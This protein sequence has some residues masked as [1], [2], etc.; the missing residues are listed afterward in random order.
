MEISG[1]GGEKIPIFPAGKVAI[2][3]AEQSVAIQIYGC[4]EMVFPPRKQLNL[5]FI[6][7]A[8]NLIKNQTLQ[9]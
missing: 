7:V 5:N 9:I 1:G 4:F 2:L 3:I 6:C 8:K